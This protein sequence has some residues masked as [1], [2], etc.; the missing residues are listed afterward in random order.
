MQ[1]TPEMQASPLKQCS[2]LAAALLGLF[3]VLYF[4]A[5]MT[6]GSKA[7]EGLT[8]ATFLCLI[9]GLIIFLVTGFFCRDISPVAV[10]GV[11]TL[12]RLMIVGIGALVDIFEP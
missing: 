2:I 11:S 5:Q 9:P 10:M 7:V 8:Y 1:S 4:P 6:V 3:A 12:L